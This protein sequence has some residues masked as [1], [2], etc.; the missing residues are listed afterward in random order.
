MKSNTGQH[1]E[2]PWAAPSRDFIPHIGQ[3]GGNSAPLC[4]TC[5][6]ASLLSYAVAFQRKQHFFC[7]LASVTPYRNAE[8]KGVDPEEV[9]YCPFSGKGSRNSRFLKP[10]LL[11]PLDKMM[12]VAPSV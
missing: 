2:Q 12:A 11:Q 9:F 3:S 5:L 8:Q 4:S 1:Q 7:I 10:L 6:K